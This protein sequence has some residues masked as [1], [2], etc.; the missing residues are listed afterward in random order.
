MA[1][2]MLQPT[3][4]NALNLLCRRL[5]QMHE[6]ALLIG[7]DHIGATIVVQIRGCDLGA[8]AAVLVNQVGKEGGVALAVAL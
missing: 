1:G 6:D 4:A 7:N 8:H 3:L 5:T 2:S